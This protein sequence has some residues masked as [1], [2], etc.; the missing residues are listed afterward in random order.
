[1]GRCRRMSGCVKEILFKAAERT[2]VRLTLVA[3]QFIRIPPS[4]YIDML[5]VGRGFDVTDNEIVKRVE[6]NDLVITADI[7]LAAE[8]IEKDAH[9]FNPRYELNT[10]AILNMREC[11]DTLRFSGIETGSF[12]SIKATRTT[13]FC[14]SGR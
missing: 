1:M 12:F 6:V 10:K 2:Q 9:A 11:M 5:Q 8:V 14:E 4:R 13:R 7:P 3:N